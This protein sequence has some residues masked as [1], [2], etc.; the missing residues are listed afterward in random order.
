MVVN[1]QYAGEAEHLPDV[2]FL[3][4]DCGGGSE[5][6]S[7]SRMR[8]EEEQQDGEEDGGAAGVSRK[9]KRKR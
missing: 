5:G 3:L 7:G 9:R 8:D 4:C 6:R 2:A 1:R